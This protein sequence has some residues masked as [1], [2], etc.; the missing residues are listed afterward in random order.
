[1]QVADLE[2]KEIGFDGGHI[3]NMNLNDILI[4]I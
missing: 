4:L 3:N 2:A 1:V